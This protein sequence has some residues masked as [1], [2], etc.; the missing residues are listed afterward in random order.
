MPSRRKDVRAL[1]IEAQLEV[2]AAHVM[3]ARI[4]H[5]GPDRHFFR[6]DRVYWVDLCLTPR[7]NGDAARYS[8]HWN[9]SRLVALG[10]LLAF[11]PRKRLELRSGGGD[12]GSLICQLKAE[13]VDRWLPDDFV[14][15]ERRLEVSLNITSESIKSLM[16]KLNHELRNG[17]VGTV[18]YCEAIVAELAIELAR[19]LL[20][21]SDTDEKGGLASWRQR[22]IDER[23]VKPGMAFPTVAELAALCKMSPRQ[24]SRAFRT[25]RGCSV[26]DYLVQTR[27]EVAKR[28]L[29]TRESIHDIAA[30][31]GFS[32]Q[33]SF[34]AAFRRST[35]ATPNSFRQRVD[36]GRD[37]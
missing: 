3:I 10:P 15:T 4:N 29:C 33:S 7:R 24:L 22:I 6:R 17:N 2:P 21:A 12:H 18:P 5:D 36:L 35:G 13:M 1:E 23:I 19:Y 34:T 31:L 14:W 32:S 37:A 11:P 28:R 26:S 9:P 16:L 25:S 20:A 30:Q 8:D 27:I